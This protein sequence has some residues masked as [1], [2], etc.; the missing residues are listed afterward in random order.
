MDT[1]SSVTS[2]HTPRDRRGVRHRLPVTETKGAL[3][4]L[5]PR[6]G[7]HVVPSTRPTPSRPLRSTQR[8]PRRLL[9]L[10]RGTFCPVP[11]LR[12]SDDSLRRNTSRTTRATRDPSRSLRSPPPQ[13]PHPQ[14]PYPPVGLRGLPG[15]PDRRWTCPPTRRRVPTLRG[16]R[17][18]SRP[19]SFTR[20]GVEVPVST[21]RGPPPNPSQAS[22]SVEGGTEDDRLL[23][24]VFS[25]F[26]RVF[27]NKDHADPPP[28]QRR[29]GDGPTDPQP[30]DDHPPGRDCPLPAHG[31]G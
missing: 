20:E 1:A 30:P 29:A 17:G 28:D 25:L 10:L 31:S 18:K 19:H 16:S 21:S 26:L 14:P 9:L 4:R 8:G 12:E 7:V 15:D 24:Y 2:R 13:R 6:T 27:G 23:I 3:T 22:Q 11:P 5:P